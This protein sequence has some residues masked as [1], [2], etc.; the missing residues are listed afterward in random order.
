MIISILDKL[1][2]ISDHFFDTTLFIKLPCT[3]IPNIYIKHII[4]K[5]TIVKN[6][7]YAYITGNSIFGYHITIQMKPQLLLF[8][9]LISII[10]FSC[11]PND[12]PPPA[13]PNIIFLLTDDQRWDAMGAMGN[14]HIKTP[15][16]DRLAYDGIR[17]QH[18]YVTTPI[19]AISRASIF[20]GQYARRHGIHNFA[21]PFDSTQWQNT[22]PYLM[23]KAGYFTGFL[24]KFGVGRELPAEE[25]DFWRGV[26]G[27]PKYEHTDENGNYI[28]YTKI[29]ENQALTF[30]DTIPSENP[31]CLSVS[32][33]APHVQD[34]DPRQFL[35][36][37]AY[38]TLFADVTLPPPPMREDEY[39][40][41]FP[42]FFKADNESRRRWN[43]R[44]ADE[45][46][47]QRS[48]KGYYRLIYGVDVFIGAVLEKL[49]QMGQADN[50]VIVL[51]GDN[52]FFLGERGLAGKWYAYD[53]SIH[54]PLFIYDPRLPAELRGQLIEPIALNIDI[55]PTLLSM[56]GIHVPSSMQGEDLSALY[57]G[58][59]PEDWR[60]D[61]LFEHPFDHPRIPKSEGVV[62]LTE[63]Y[64]I[65]PEV[66]PI[67]EEYYDLV[68][69]PQEDNNLI[70]DPNYAQQIEHIRNRMDTLIQRYQ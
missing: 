4:Y 64:F 57:K 17:F 50:T 53:E 24:G 36:D 22:Y 1:C 30:L 51:L 25:F 15:N 60:T 48:V 35:Y 45:E 21:K 9:T 46:M 41:R 28:H 34:T 49:E 16:M 70:K 19:C 59:N 14:E 29:L 6:T 56:A 42:E 18:A 10:L 5:L 62:S 7:T 55:A 43:M 40:E 63:K 23:R 54:V 33:K 11:T 8:S 31:F 13:P 12:P 38:Q 65:Y 69:D 44:F 37:S 39:W 58:N 52:G 3:F 61:F 2:L 26:P 47:Y 20:S 66:D 67:H 32:F 27:Q 68:K